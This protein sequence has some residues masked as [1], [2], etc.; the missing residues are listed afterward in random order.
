MLRFFRKSWSQRMLSEV[1]KQR[2][3]AEYLQDT[4]EAERLRRLRNYLLVRLATNSWKAR[5]LKHL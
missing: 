5:Y 3:I 1:L 2:Q 4:Q